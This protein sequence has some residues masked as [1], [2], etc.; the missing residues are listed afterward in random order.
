MF[1]ITKYKAHKKVY[2]RKRS[3]NNEFAYKI[4][5]SNS[6]EEMGLKEKNHTTDYNY[7]SLSIDLFLLSTLLLSTLLL[8]TLLLSTL[9][10]STSNTFNF[11]N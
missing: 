6:V 5:H 8:S 4:R 7:Y 9:L 3:G 2:A 10:L 11:P 1:K